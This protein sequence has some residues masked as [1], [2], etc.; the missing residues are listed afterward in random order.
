MPSPPEVR[1]R[2][3]QT[4]PRRNSIRWRR[5]PARSAPGCKAGTARAAHR[6][7]A[8]APRKTACSSI[9][10]S[11]MAEAGQ[12]SRSPN[13]S[14]NSRNSSAKNSS[15][16]FAAANCLKSSK[17]SRTSCATARWRR[18]R[19]LFARLSVRLRQMNAAR[20]ASTGTAC[21]ARNA[22][23]AT[24]GEPALRERP[25]VFLDGQNVLRRL[26][27]R[28]RLL[29][30]GQPWHRRGAGG[31]D[32]ER[33]G[34]LGQRVI[35]AVVG[36]EERKRQAPAVHAHPRFAARRFPRMFLFP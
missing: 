16:L 7:V 23:R 15:G 5:A 25:E 28:R 8:G 9:T 3:F 1:G 22:G 33:H 10:F 24:S 11:V 14:C 2:F 35:F 21:A 17:P 20:N 27:F 30:R 31:L 6:S 4:S 36:I 34:G 26:V 19:G 13:C 12:S 29:G 18:R 32:G